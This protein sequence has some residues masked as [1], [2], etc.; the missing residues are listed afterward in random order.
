MQREQIKNKYNENAQFI[1]SK[2]NINGSLPLL[3]LVK[4]A[5]KSEWLIR[6]KNFLPK[7]E[8]KSDVLAEKRK[9]F[10]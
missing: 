3:S 9:N 4:K 7:K 5:P 8:W 1:D 6:R 10:K 2:F